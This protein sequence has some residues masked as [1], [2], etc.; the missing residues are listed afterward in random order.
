[1]KFVIIL[2]PSR[3]DG[4][5]EGGLREAEGHWAPVRRPG[6]GEESHQERARE[7]GKGRE[8]KVRCFP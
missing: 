3:N 7:E 1:M 5:R 2:I 4:T 6:R 8:E